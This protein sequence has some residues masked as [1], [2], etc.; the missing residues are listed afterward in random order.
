MDKE[1]WIYMRVLP[2]GNVV[3]DIVADSSRVIADDKTCKDVS[4]L[5]M[6]RGNVSGRIVVIYST[7]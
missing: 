2:F 7:C 1:I 6:I 5:N 4:I 3:G